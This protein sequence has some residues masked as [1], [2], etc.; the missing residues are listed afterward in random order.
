MDKL[1]LGQENEK[2]V[3]DLLAQLNDASILKMSVNTHKG[4]NGMQAPFLEDQKLGKEGI[5]PD[6]EAR[7][8]SLKA[9][10]PKPKEKGA[11]AGKS[12]HRGDSDVASS[13]QRPSKGASHVERS[14]SG[15][16]D[17]G[18]SLDAELLARLQALKGP[19][20]SSQM[21]EG[22]ET[23]K[24]SSGSNTPTLSEHL[25]ALKSRP[26]KSPQRSPS[27]SDYPAGMTVS[28]TSVGSA[29]WCAPTSPFKLMKA[30]SVKKPVPDHSGPRSS[31]KSQS[32]QSKD[33]K[34]A[35]K[36]SLSH[37]SKED[38]RV[39]PS[40]M[41]ADVQRLLAA[42][43]RE[44]RSE[45]DQSTVKEAMFAGDK[46]TFNMKDRDVELLKAME[47]EEAIALEAEKVVEWAKDNARLEGSDK[48][49]QDELDE[50]E[51]S[52]SDDSDDSTGAK[53]M[54]AKKKTVLEDSDPEEA[55]GKPKKRKGR[56]RWNFL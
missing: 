42:V 19:S 26:K 16:S 33:A 48:E 32:S 27:R 7:Y 6:L 31:P 17:G 21:P 10:R 41:V 45:R 36:R 15:G 38:D 29:G 50:V 22:E 12:K 30:L 13:P 1:Y 47:D 18:D 2:D 11:T 24:P 40:E 43:S 28:S 56:R 3:D 8:A 52:W 4:T 14:S 23:L 9:P 34:K 20:V 35:V 53:L 55:T 49:S 37:T 51:V 44:G 39:D 46:R 25:Q 5:D 54:S